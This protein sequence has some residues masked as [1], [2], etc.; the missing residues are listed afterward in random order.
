MDVV[1]AE[2][3]LPDVISRVQP[4]AASSGPRSEGVAAA[5]GEGDC[6]GQAVAYPLGRCAPTRRPFAE[7]LFSVTL[8]AHEARR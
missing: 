1:G 2:V 4:V 7:P 6:G 5:C 8:E 3:Y